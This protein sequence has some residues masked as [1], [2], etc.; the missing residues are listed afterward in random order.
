MHVEGGCHCG[1]IAYEAEVDPETVSICH[2]TDCQRMTGMD[3]VVNLE[4]LP[5]NPTQ[6]VR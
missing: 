5:Q 6:I 4:S 2:C 3:W 1:Y